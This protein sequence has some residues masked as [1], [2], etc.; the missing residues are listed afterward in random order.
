[1]AVLFPL[2]LHRVDEG[3]VG[4]YWFGGRL[5]QGTTKPGYHW[6]LP[7]TSFRNIQVTMQTDQV[8]DIPCGTSGGVI[9]YFQK[10]EVVNR[11]REEYVYETI[12]NYTI[13][14]DQ[15]WIFDRIHHAM[16]EFCSVSTLQEVYIDKFSQLDESLARSLQETCNIWA[17][18]IEI[19]AIRVTKPRIPESIRHNY[20]QIEAEK[21]KLL[22]AAQAQKV[23]VAEAQTQTKKAVAEAE[24]QLAVSRITSEKLIA[25]KEARRNVTAIEDEMHLTRARAHADAEYYNAASEADANRLLLTPAYLMSLK[26]QSLTEHAQIVYGDSVPTALGQMPAAF[27]RDGERP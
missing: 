1:M 12:K 7:V 22:I 11:L 16:N 15:T 20:E 3:F 17:P 25:E 13:N 2:G 6:K 4:V 18:G 26:V 21:T 14:Y 24:K 8:T 19:I 23:V 10:I 9:I 5:L 27:P